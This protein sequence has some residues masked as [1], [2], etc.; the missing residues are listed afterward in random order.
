MFFPAKLPFE[1]LPRELHSEKLNGML[2]SLQIQNICLS[3][4]TFTP[5]PCGHIHLCVYTAAWPSPRVP[6]RP[7][8]GWAQPARPNLSRVARQRCLLQLES[9]HRCKLFSKPVPWPLLHYIFPEKGWPSGLRG[10]CKESEGGPQP[11]HGSWQLRCPPETPA[12]SHR[13]FAKEIL[14][15]P[16]RFQPNWQTLEK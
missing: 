4:P 2:K 15:L 6:T 9:F 16:P 11:R 3:A 14:V 1:F 5:F 13:T 8:H 7:W 12:S 10:P